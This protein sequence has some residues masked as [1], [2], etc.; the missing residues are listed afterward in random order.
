MQKENKKKMDERGFVKYENKKKNF[1][2][3]MII[4]S[5]LLLFENYS[6]IFFF[7]YYY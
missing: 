2:I 5:R 3:S 7:F 4:F 1:E 6:L